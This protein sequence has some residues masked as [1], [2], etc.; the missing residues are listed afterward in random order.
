M[1]LSK[2]LKSGKSLIVLTIVLLTLTTA[3]SY[4]QTTTWK[5]WQFGL[6]AGANVFK[7]TGRSF[8]NKT[9]IG[10]NGGAYGEY[11]ISNQWGI[12]PELEYNLVQSKTGD[13]FGQIYPGGIS[14]D[15]Q[16][17]YVTVPV[18]LTFKPVPELS[19][20]AGPQYGFL[21]AQTSGLFGSNTNYNYPKN[22]F[23][24]SD[25]SIAFGA[26][27]NLGKVKIGM[28]YVAGILNINGINDSD[29]WK[30]QGLQAY[31]GYR[32]F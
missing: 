31:L 11:K 28:R 3:N 25:F 14:S 22:A 5:N 23:S 18:F 27:L 24:K 16:L 2:Q 9:H 7:L 12:Q 10:F 4:A 20:M 8:D 17:N 19:I 32:I 21:V 1:K 15:I 13:Q 26:Q 30:V 29:T 6:K